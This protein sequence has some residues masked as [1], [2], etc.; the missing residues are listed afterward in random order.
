MC[1]KPEFSDAER[2]R[3]LQN[4]LNRVIKEYKPDILAIEK[5]YFFKNLKTIIP[6]SQAKG[7]VLLTAAKKKMPIFEF[8]PL[9]VKMMITGYGR[10]KKPVLQK[11][12][13]SLLKLKQIPKYDDAADALGVAICCAR[14][15]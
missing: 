7:V 12:V 14:E 1:T 10:A 5:I 2:L 15:I 9:Q 4:Q 8:T 13:K 11:K 3:Q 6:V